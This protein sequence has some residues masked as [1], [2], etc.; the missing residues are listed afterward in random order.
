MLFLMS[1]C[2]HLPKHIPLR[3][4]HMI[5]FMRASPQPFIIIS[6]LLA[7]KH[8][9]S[10]PILPL[11][12]SANPVRLLLAVPRH[13]DWARLPGPTRLP[14]WAHPPL[15]PKRPPSP[16]LAH[17]CSPSLPLARVSPSPVSFT[18]SHLS[19]GPDSPISPSPPSSP[20]QNRSG[21]PS[22]MHSS[23]PFISPVPLSASHPV[24][25]SQHA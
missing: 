20:P 2:F 25:R 18:E 24:T 13:F 16:S 7:H 10:S 19:L 9:P 8:L 3:H 6:P 14:R 4:I 21:S 23:S 17:A 5:F 1:M 15:L 12:L 11:A 22:P